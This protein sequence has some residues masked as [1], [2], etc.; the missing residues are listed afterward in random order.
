MINWM[1][2]KNGEV[3]NISMANRNINGG[4]SVTLTLVAT[5]KMTSDS[6]GTF[7]NEAEIGEATNVKKI[8]DI[9]SIPGNRVNSEDDFSKAELIISIG[10]GIAVYISIGIILA[11]F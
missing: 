2:Q 11:S 3:V 6:T 7:T 10:T 5:K 1:K 9:D 4:E 8:A